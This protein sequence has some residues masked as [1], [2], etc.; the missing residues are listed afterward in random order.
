ME[1]INWFAF[2]VPILAVIG[3][4][5]FVKRSSSENWQNNNIKKHLRRALK[6]NGKYNLDD[7]NI[8]IKEREREIKSFNSKNTSMTWEDLTEGLQLLKEVRNDFLS[9]KST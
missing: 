3:G 6:S 7:I 9:E 1:R 2:L 5:I 8:L 4:F